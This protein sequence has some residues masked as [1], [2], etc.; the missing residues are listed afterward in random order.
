MNDR[1]DRSGSLPINQL[2]DFEK[3][4]VQSS[5]N[6]PGKY[7]FITASA[8]WKTH[9][10]YSH[11]TEALIFA[12]AA[13]GSLGRTHYV[14]GKFIASDLCFIL[15]ER[16]P[17]NYPIDLKFYQLI[18][19]SFKD[20]I[21][22][23]TKSGTSKEAI[24][25]QVFGNYELPYFDIEKQI[26]VREKYEKLRELKQ[27]VEYELISNMDLVKKLRQ[28]FL[29]EAM[30][31]KLTEQ[32]KED[33]NARDL[34][35][36]IKAEKAKSAKKE[37][38]LPPIKEE[39]IPFEIPKNWVWC[40]L[41]DIAINHDG[42]RIPISQVERAKRKKIYDYYGASGIIDKIDSFTHNGKFLLI[43][44]DGANLVA[45]STPIAFIAEGKFWVN[46]HAHVIGF[47]NDDTINFMEYC[48]NAIDIK[49]FI[50]GG[51]QPKLSQGNMNLIPIPF[52]PLSEQTRIVKK[53]AQLMHLCDELE[54]GIKQSQEQ[55][56]MLLQQVLREALAG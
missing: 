12:A 14:S 23:N 36:K 49:K 3:G 48:I 11:N 13:S 25:L 56:Q 38:P 31:G 55:N 53:L 37:K 33:G 45:K 39:E 7:P 43:G 40:R 32:K 54:A 6:I 10:D 50:T 17:E 22:R 9:N 2:F 19:N 46:N 20:E 47:H 16:D 35:E 8:E 5:K 42:A 44:E 29:Q 51:F 26:K 34:L 21:V 15:T 4:S 27:N 30:Q 28:S 52:P 18:F 1:G 41:G 24:G